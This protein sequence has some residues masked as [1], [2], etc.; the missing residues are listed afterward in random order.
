MGKKLIENKKDKIFVTSLGILAVLLIVLIAI[1]VMVK[2]ENNRFIDEI[3]AEKDSLSS[4]LNVLSED[5]KNLQTDNDSL[6]VQLVGEQEK[7]NLLIKNIKTFKDNSYAEISRY[8]KQINTLKTVLR[9]YVV[10]IDS[11]NRLNQALT[12]ENIQ[13][14]RQ[15]FWAKDKAEKLQKKTE[16]MEE[17]LSR[18][19]TLEAI[20]LEVYP[21]NKKG[22]QIKKI[23]KAVKLKA[24]FTLQK[25]VTAKRGVR[26]LYIRIT[27]P[28]ES[29]LLSQ[30]NGVFKY[31]GAE[32][33][34]T[35]TRDVEY[36]GERLEVSIFWDNDNTLVKGK[37]KADIFSESNL[38]GTTSFNLK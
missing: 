30:D 33:N 28:D 10:Q 17:E 20:E 13:V 6:K 32:L 23:N 25:N 26:T 24:D 7:I 1:F 36:E 9:S 3:T 34:Y 11:L 16:V 14:K 2:I 21:I 12:A 15:M 37:Y 18:A 4:E 31:Q 8:K 29:L 27:R 19:A 35:A 22:R 5:F 38:I